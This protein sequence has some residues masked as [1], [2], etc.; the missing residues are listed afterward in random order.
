MA[1]NGR[2]ER[3]HAFTNVSLFS[4]QLGTIARYSPNWRNVV[5]SNG[6]NPFELS[7]FSRQMPTI[8]RY[9]PL[10]DAERVELPRPFGR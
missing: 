8:R 9:V 4:R 1:E 3:P 2:I 6:L 10:A 5:E 7:L